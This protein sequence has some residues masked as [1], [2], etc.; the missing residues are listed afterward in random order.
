V[1]FT[2]LLLLL[3]RPERVSVTPTIIINLAPVYP[4]TLVSNIE[5]VISIQKEENA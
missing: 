2:L 4:A 1:A 3:L 5:K